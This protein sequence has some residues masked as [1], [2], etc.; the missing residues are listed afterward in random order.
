MENTDSYE[1]DQIVPNL[2]IGYMQNSSKNSSNKFQ[3]N[4]L[5]HSVKGSP[6]GGGYSTLDDLL[7]YVAALQDNKLVGLQYTTMVLGLL[8]TIKFTENIYLI[9]LSKPSVS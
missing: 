4:L 8:R 6:A 7:R 3:N 9:I 1:L 5:A 2:A